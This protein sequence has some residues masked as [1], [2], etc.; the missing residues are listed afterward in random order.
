MAWN[1]LGGHQKGSLVAIFRF[2]MLITYLWL[3]V[4][5]LR[6]AFVQKRRISIFPVLTYTG[7]VA[8][9]ACPSVTEIKIPWCRYIHFIDSVIHI[10]RWKAQG[11]LSIG[12]YSYHENSNFFWSEVIW[13]DLVTSPWATWVW[14]FQNMWWKNIWM[15]KKNSRPSSPPPSPVRINNNLTSYVAVSKF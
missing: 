5:V 10:N 4:W 6:M 14:N 11:D 9:L 7:E 2:R 13:R 15:C 1:D 3:D 12:R 8:K